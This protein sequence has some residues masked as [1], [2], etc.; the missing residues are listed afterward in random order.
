MFS[1]F[2]KRKNSKTSDAQ[3]IAVIVIKFELNSLLP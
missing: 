2:R 3:K 1:T